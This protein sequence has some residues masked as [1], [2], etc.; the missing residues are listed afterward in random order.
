MRQQCQPL[1]RQAAQRP[2]AATGLLWALPLGGALALLAGGHSAL[3]TL[4]IL[5]PLVEEIVFRA[6]L[7][8]AL[9]RHAVRP[10]AAWIANA[11]TA[12]AFSAA[13]LALRPGVAAA[14]TVLP[15]LA[16]GHLYEQRRQVAPCAALHS[17]FN[18]VWLLATARLA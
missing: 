11:L 1:E 17:L 3:A 6:G 18:A 9:L 2:V 4:L 10:D 8:E 5:A 7:Q 13:H 16:C 12:L 14:L 15:A